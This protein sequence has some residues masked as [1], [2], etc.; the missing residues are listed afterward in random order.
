M[1]WLIITILAYFILAVVFLIDKYL[2]VNA[3]PNPKVYAFLI[4]IAG[5]LLLVLIPF[6][7]FYI[8]SAQQIILSFFAGATFI[9][10]LYWF[11]K[12]LQ[13]FDASQIVPAVG[14]L[15]PFFVLSF[16]YISSL[17]KEFPSNREILSIILLVAGAVLITIEK[18]KTIN[19]ESMKL[20]L[21]AALFFSLSFVLTKYVY[22]EQPFLNGLIWT[23]LG[24]VLMALILFF[25]WDDI[26]K[27]IFGQKDAFKRKSLG[28]LILNQTAGAGAGLLQNWAIA[29]APLL[30][31]AFINALQGVQYVFL[32]IFSIVLSFKF[33]QILKEQ[34][35]KEVIVQRII[36]IFLI[37]GGLV[38]LSI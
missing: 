25:L 8:P 22:L 33:P 23:R 13:N 24:G 6:V 14:A 12:A 9:F 11:Y 7:N 15:N 20:S 17:G 35:T 16:V 34:I 29:L 27:D 2:L 4:G 19:G 31:V 18:G 1:N 26:K 30:Y 32:L 10:A 37:G 3:I 28:I 38:L 36:A 5:L 21:M